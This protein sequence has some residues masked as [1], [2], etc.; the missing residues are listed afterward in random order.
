MLDPAENY[1]D[2]GEL[3]RSIIKVRLASLIGA[4]PDGAPSDPEIYVR[5]MLEHVCAI[6]DLCL[7]ALDAACREIVATQKFL[8][9]PSEVLATVSDQQVKCHQRMFAITHV[10]RDLPGIV[11]LIE[12]LEL[13]APKAAKAEY[14][15]AAKRAVEKAQQKLEQAQRDAID[16]EDV[17]CEASAA[18]RD[19]EEAF[20]EAKR[21]VLECENDLARAEAVVN[22]NATASNDGQAV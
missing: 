9:S 13:E 5:M 14:M 22:N 2:D 15:A 11:S 4:Y 12:K 3:R 19:S 8:P 16:A 10:G 1:D 6:E 18:L 20:A 7:P 17:Y 21:R